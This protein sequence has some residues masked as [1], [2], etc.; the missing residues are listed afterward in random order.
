MFAIT[1]FYHRYFAHKTFQAN[2]V[3]QFL[4]AYIG[5]MATQ[6]GPLWWASNHRHHH[7]HTDTDQDPHTPKKGFWYSHM[8][9][10]LTH[11]HVEVKHELIKD[12]SRF[13]ELKWLDKY[14]LVAPVSLAVALIAT[15]AYL[16]ATHPDL[17]ITAAQLF[18]WGFL[19]STIALTHITLC[20]NS[21]AHVL[22]SRTY[23]TPDTSR[24]NLIL[25]ILTLGEGWHNNHHFYQGSVRQGFRWWQIDLTYYILWL[26]SKV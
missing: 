17:G 8:G 3:V 2:R 11:E 10:F 25:A 13:P 26:M 1:G 7:R 22:G 6:K 16:Q 19:I 12:W 24:N 14:H 9:W 5:A 15:G 18:V 21:V 20:V 4:F 23:N